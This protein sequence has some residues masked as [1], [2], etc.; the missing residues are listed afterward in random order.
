MKRFLLILIIFVLI[1]LG[2]KF[3]ER[4]PE[5]YLQSIGYLVEKNIIKGFPDGTFKVDWA[6]TEAEFLTLI[7]RCN[8]KSKEEETNLTFFEKIINL[9]KS[10]IAIFK[11]K[12]IDKFKDYKDKWF[13]PF[14]I[15][16]LNLT[17]IKEKQIEPYLF[18]NIYEAL[19]FI[20]KASPYKGEIENITFPL[21]NKAKSIIII[22]SISHRYFP[23]EIKFREKLS[24]GDAFLL[25][26]KYLR[27]KEDVTNNWYWKYKHS[28]RSV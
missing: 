14:L 2:V 16:Y 8:L 7:V 5:E 1:S 28:F 12:N 15:E 6:I 3:Q 9:Y 25:I 21:D 11:R 26:E 24:R 17:G 23:Q 22:A 27:S 20:L 19:Y 13:H 10:L 4:I 18:L